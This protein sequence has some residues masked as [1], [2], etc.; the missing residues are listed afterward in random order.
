MPITPQLSGE[1]HC[2]NPSLTTLNHVIA[3]ICTLA[4]A[5]RCNKPQSHT[6]CGQLL[7]MQALGDNL[8][9]FCSFIERT[10]P[11]AFSSLKHVSEISG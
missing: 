2:V 7:E 11:L 3:Q 10:Q 4:A 8:A 5:V 6:A 9:S 1:I